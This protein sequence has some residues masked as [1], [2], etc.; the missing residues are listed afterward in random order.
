MSFFNYLYP[1]F[2]RLERLTDFKNILLKTPEYLFHFLIVN[3]PIAYTLYNNTFNINIFCVA[4]LGCGILQGI[5]NSILYYVSDI[6]FFGKQIDI[7]LWKKTNFYNLSVY[8]TDAT[9]LYVIGAMAYTSLTIV[10][11]SMRWTISYPGYWIILLQIFNLF[12]L[13]D[14]F[15]TFIHYFVHKIKYFR[16]PHLKWHHDCPFDIGSSRCATATEGIEGLFRDLYSAF[17]PTYIISYCGIPFSCYTW[18][19]YYSLYSFWAMYI[20]TGVNI[21]HKIHHSANYNLN[22]GIYYITDYLIGTLVLTE[23]KN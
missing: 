16:I 19:I 2:L 1:N 22:Y 8:N 10:P 7:N 20:H 6:L 21:Y 9:Y 4:Y 18:I 11:E 3:S 5:I 15:F 17:I 13:H 14:V 23:K 12:I